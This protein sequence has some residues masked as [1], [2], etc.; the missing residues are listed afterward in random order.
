MADWHLAQV[1]IGRLIAP[2]RD[3]RVQPFFDALDRINA[4]AEASPGFVWRLKGEGN[5]ATDIQATPDPLL[6]PNM[7]VW[8]DAEAL[9]D[10]VYRSAHTP[11]MARR[12]DYFERF[13]G[14]YQALW[15][16]PAGETPTVSDALARLWMLERFGPS[17]HAFTFKTRFPAPGLGGAPVDQASSLWPDPWCVG[18]A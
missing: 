10:F 14:A 6:I 3:P 2:P 17:P 12:R 18:N 16:I 7:S 8:A 11:V 4:L 15:W 5:N 9:F 1:N 13:E